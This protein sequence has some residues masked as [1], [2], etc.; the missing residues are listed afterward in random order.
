[1]HRANS[2]VPVCL[3]ALALGL[4]AACSDEP[5]A[6]GAQR[7]V[8]EMGLFPDAGVTPASELQPL[9]EV[10]EFELKDQEGG[11]FARRFM[12][13]QVW[14]V[15]FL[16]TRC[17]SICPQIAQ[18]MSELAK[19]WRRV[20]QVQF[21][22]FTVDPEHDTPAV[23]K[24]YLEDRQL[25]HRDWYLLTGDREK[26]RSLCLDSF[27]LALGDEMDENGDITHSSRFVLVDQSGTIR[28]YYD[29]LDEE[30]RR[31]LDK[32]IRGLMSLS[33]LNPPSD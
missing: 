27:K 3:T 30:G 5:A 1:M 13:G 11:S 14:V 24:Q 32:A 20:P 16:F 12:N 31:N 33:E 7:P 6:A 8:A 2:W 23:L 28:G 22:S 15:S 10:A 26:I 21:L 19:A 17:P 18:R 29:A 9:G 25:F 4:L